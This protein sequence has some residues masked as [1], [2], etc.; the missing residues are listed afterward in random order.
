[1][2]RI[3][4]V[5]AHPALQ[6]SFANKALLSAIQETDNITVHDLYAV[7]PDSFIDVDHEQGLV[8]AHDVIVFQHPFYWYSCPGLLK[9]WIDLVLERASPTVPT[10]SPCGANPGSQC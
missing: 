8:L 4:V 5:F 10:G 9:D 3:L 7:Y 6:H 2:K 1:M